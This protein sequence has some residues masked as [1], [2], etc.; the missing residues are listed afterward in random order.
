MGKKKGGKK[1]DTT[2]RNIVLITALA[3]LIKSL[4]DLIERLVKLLN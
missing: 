3:N 1:D 2:L 4:M